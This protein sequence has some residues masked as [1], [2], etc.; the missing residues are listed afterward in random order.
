MPPYFGISLELN[1]TKIVILQKWP[2]CLFGLVTD[3]KNLKINYIFMEIIRKV[4]FANV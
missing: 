3:T 4:F 2:Y 1:L